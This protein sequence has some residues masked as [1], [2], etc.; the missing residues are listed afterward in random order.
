MT[1]RVKVVG[2]ALALVT[3]AS[4]GVVA[5]AAGATERV[6]VACGTT[7]G[8]CPNPPTRDEQPPVG[9]G[10]LRCPECGRI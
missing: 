9:S 5:G 8:F 4:A 2:L 1:D 7:P 10:G 6:V 3:A